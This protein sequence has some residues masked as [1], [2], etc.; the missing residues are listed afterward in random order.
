MML[1]HKTEHGSSPAMP[2]TKSWYVL[3]TFF[4]AEIIS[5]LACIQTV[6]R[7]SRLRRTRLIC[8]LSS[9]SPASCRMEKESRVETI[10]KCSCRSEGNNYKK[11]I[12]FGSQK[13]DHL[14]R[15]FAAPRYR[16]TTNLIYL[17]PREDEPDNSVSSTLKGILSCSNA[18]TGRT[19]FPIEPMEWRAPKNNWR[20]EWKGWF[21]RPAA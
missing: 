19:I 13:L 1:H 5:V 15:L 4:L 8:L 6:C 17:N 7:I 21:A 16:W 18:T 9:G 2:T 10:Q 20:K 14:Y 12:I 11:S 3:N